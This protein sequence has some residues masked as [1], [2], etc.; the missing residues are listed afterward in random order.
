MP[1]GIIVDCPISIFKAKVVIVIA[2]HTIKGIMVSFRYLDKSATPSPPKIAGIT[3]GETGAK[4]VTILVEKMLKGISPMRIISIVTMVDTA[5]E[6]VVMTSSSSLPCFVLRIVW[7]LIAQ[8][9]FKLA[10]FPV[11]KVWY[12]PPLPKRGA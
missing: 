2:R 4:I 10:M 8:G 11:I 9:S 1:M 12:C 5:T 3:Y 6:M 7:V